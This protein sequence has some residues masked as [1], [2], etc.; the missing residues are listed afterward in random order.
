MGAARLIPAAGAFGQ[1]KAQRV[2]GYKND[3][4][5]TD[6]CCSHSA[7]YEINGMFLCSKHAGVLA[8]HILLGEADDART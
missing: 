7:R 5:K 2:H 3:T 8:L 6:K 1:C 4:E